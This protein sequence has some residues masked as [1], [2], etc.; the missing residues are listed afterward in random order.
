MNAKVVLCQ[1]LFDSIK[2]Y[3][4]ASGGQGGWRAYKVPKDIWSNVPENKWNVSKHFADMLCINNFATYINSHFLI[5]IIENFI[6][7]HHFVP[8]DV[9]AVAN[10]LYK[11]IICF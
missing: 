4:Y 11:T 5:I 3:I 9:F 6:G 1:H 8:L 2:H 7:S 10:Q